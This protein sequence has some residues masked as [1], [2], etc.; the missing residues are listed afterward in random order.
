MIHVEHIAV[1]PSR[2]LGAS[3]APG[4]PALAGLTL[5]DTAACVGCDAD[6]CDAVHVSRVTLSSAH[7]DHEERA[8]WDALAD[9]VGDGWALT[10]TGE[11]RCPECRTAADAG[12]RS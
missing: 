7:A 9:A 5:R 6:G 3:P 12:V 1:R 8:A 10:S 11:P 2:I 4:Y